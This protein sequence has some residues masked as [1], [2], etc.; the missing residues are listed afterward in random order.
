MK[1]TK[2]G[3][4]EYATQYG[5]TDSAELEDAVGKKEVKL[6]FNTERE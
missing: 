2:K 6:S 5:Y 3:L 4:E 1:S